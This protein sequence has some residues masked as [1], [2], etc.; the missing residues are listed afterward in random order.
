MLEQLKTMCAARASLLEATKLALADVVLETEA[1]TARD[2]S[3]AE[4]EATMRK[5][6]ARA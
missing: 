2:Q 3:V 1:S 6:P 4:L 5:R